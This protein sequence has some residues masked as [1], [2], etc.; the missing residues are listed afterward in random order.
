MIR[1]KIIT[2]GQTEESFVRSLLAPHLAG[3]QII[4]IPITIPTA[5]GKRTHRGGIGS[6]TRMRRL[7]LGSFE[8]TGAYITTMIDLYKLPESF[9]GMQE[10]API[11]DP[12]QR[13]QL[14]EEA[15]RLDIDNRFFLPYIQLHEFETLLFSDIEGIDAHMRVY[16][17]SRLRDLRNI[18]RDYPGGPEYIN[19]GEMT[20]PSKR[21]LKVYPSY[22]KVLDGSQIAKRISLGPMREKCPHFNSWISGLEELSRREPI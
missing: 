8:R 18:L 21:L 19:D 9:P 11:T 1:L 16:T 6:Y 7:I 2:E 20:A 3:H 22:R 17:R 10:A 12:Y 5:V 14:L 15:L 4:A 13:I